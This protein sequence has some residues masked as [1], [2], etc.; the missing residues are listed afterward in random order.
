MRNY[1][2]A[3]LLLGNVEQLSS[4]PSECTN[5]ELKAHAKVTNHHADYIQQV[6]M[7]AW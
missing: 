7:L 4:A 1:A 3:I 5:A 6:T 2:Q